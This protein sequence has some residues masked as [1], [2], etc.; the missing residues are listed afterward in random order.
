[1]ISFVATSRNLKKKNLEKNLMKA[2]S[3]SNSFTFHT[4]SCTCIIVYCGFLNY[5]LILLITAWYCEGSWFPFPWIAHQTSRYWNQNLLGNLRITFIVAYHQLR[6]SLFWVTYI[7]FN[8]F[9]GLQWYCEI[10]MGDRALCTYSCCPTWDVCQHVLW[11]S[12]LYTGTCK[13]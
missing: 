12:S 3:D 7:G 5:S 13:W 6:Y 10:W 9:E 2:A 11:Q 4:H 8:K 1:M